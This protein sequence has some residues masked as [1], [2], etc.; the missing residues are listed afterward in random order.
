MQFHK[1]FEHKHDILSLLLCHVAH[2]INT[3][4]WLNCDALAQG[5]VY[6]SIKEP[7]N[8]RGPGGEQTHDF[9]TEAT[10]PAASYP[11]RSLHVTKIV[12]KT[13]SQ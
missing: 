13:Q 2:Y 3:Y 9:Q 7:I 10:P 6:K 12:S 5:N 4:I 1:N 11:A 8:Y